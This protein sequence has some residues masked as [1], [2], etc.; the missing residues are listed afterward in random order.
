MILGK[1]CSLEE[2]ITN[3]TSLIESLGIKIEIAAWRNIVP[4]AT[5]LKV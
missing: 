4:H 3:M 5:R 1:D 2:T